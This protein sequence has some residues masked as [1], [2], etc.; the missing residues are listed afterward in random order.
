M[1]ATSAQILPKLSFQNIDF[2]SLSTNALNVVNVVEDEDGFLWIATKIGVY[3]YDGYA[4]RT[5]IHS[6]DP[7]TINENAAALI[8][9]DSEENIWVGTQSGGINKYIPELDQFERLVPPDGVMSRIYGFLEDGNT[10]FWIVAQNGLF[11]YDRRTNKLT[12]YTPSDRPKMPRGFGFR[13]VSRDES[14]DAALWVA[15]LDGLYRFETETKQFEYIPMPFRVYSQSYYMLMNLY[16]APDQNLIGGSWGG[17]ILTYHIPSNTWRKDT[18]ELLDDGRWHNVIFSLLPEGDNHIWV[19]GCSGFGIFQRDIGEYAYYQWD[20]NDP[21]SIDSSFCYGGLLKTKQNNMV[22][23]RMNGISISSSLDPQN[24]ALKFQPVISDI[25]IDGQPIFTD[26]AMHYVRQLFMKGE[27]KDLSVSLLSPGNYNKSL[28][29]SYMLEGYDGNW[30]I[31]P[32]GRTIRYTNLPDGKYRFRYRASLNEEDWI[33]G[34]ALRVDRAVYFWQTSWFI[35]LG[36]LSVLSIALLIYRLKI[37]SIHRE[38]SLKSEYNKKLAEV[39]LQALRAQMNPHFMFN[40]LNS[41]KH[42]ILTHEPLKASEY[43]TN[44]ATLI[45]SIMHNSREKLISLSKE[46]EALFLYV[47]LEQLRFK[48]K[49][50]FRCEV[51]EE[52]NTEKIL[53]PPLL[54]Q[55]YVENAIWH[56]LL[57]KSEPG[58]LEISIMNSNGDTQCII[59]DNGIGRWAAEQKKSKSATRFKS[60]GMGI[61]ESRIA[62]HNRINE[63]GIRVEI[64]DLIGADK[65]ALGTQVIITIPNSKSDQIG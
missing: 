8:Y 4:L 37:N 60:M 38:A 10:H 2:W 1:Q 40:C 57:H 34:T 21:A 61:T 63:L 42:Y 29:F 54:L 27:D 30:Q 31:L 5:Y 16:A 26:T 6:S 24:D 43:L 35:L 17:G 45:R 22:V 44:F 28:I 12:K 14:K 39:E 25:R 7:H 50:D 11:Y 33:E 13:C 18:S 23:T 19:A 53:I 55:P 36:I 59:Q 64:V 47:D 49:F 46:L 58:N 62:L 15:G 20:P 56:G 48:D 65:E 51:G 3:R 9:K 32:E 41:I 52:I